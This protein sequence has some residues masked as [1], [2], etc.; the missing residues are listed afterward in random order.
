MK[1][2][3][4]VTGLIIGS[5]VWIYGLSLANIMWFLKFYVL[6]NLLVGLLGAIVMT[7]FSAFILDRLRAMFKMK[8]GISAL[9]F[10]LISCAPSIILSLIR[11][12]ITLTLADT[13]YYNGQF[14]GAATAGLFSMGWLISAAAVSAFTAFMLLLSRIVY[15]GL[16]ARR[17]NEHKG[18]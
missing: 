2:A 6:E 3:L 12:T 18:E 16:G 11:V 9:W 4:S 17:Q 7:A 8:Y 14:L 1:K 10:F 15:S 13:G 5:I